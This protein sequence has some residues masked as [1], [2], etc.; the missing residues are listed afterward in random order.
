MIGSEIKLMIQ[1]IRYEL[2]ENIMPFWMRR[3]LDSAGNGFIGR[4]SNDLVVD[5]EAPKGLILNT[6]LL[7]SF[8]AFHR[9]TKH[10]ESLKMAHF[11][12]D[13]IRQYFWDAEHGGSFW[14]LRPDGSP[15]V[16]SKKIYG[17]A[18]L[19]YAM[20]EYYLCTGNTEALNIAQTTFNLIDQYAL[21]RDYSGYFEV[22]N[23]DWSLAD[24]Q[25]LGDEDM[26]EKKSMNN[27]LHLM[28][29]F[30]TLY[31]AWNHPMIA[32][33]LQMVITLFCDTILNADSGHLVLFF[34][35]GWNR[36]SQT[37][38]FGHDIEASWLLCEA[39]EALGDPAVKEKAESAAMKIAQVTCDSAINPRGGLFYEI[40]E[41][42][43]LNAN[44]EY[45]CQAEAA[46][47][48]LNAYQVTRNTPFLDAAVGIWTYIRNHQT[49]KEYG[50]W[51][52]RIGADNT[53]VFGQPKVS[54]WKDP[55]H[56]GR[57]CMEL[58]RRLTA[59]ITSSSPSVQ[60]EI[61]TDEK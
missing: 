35:Q 38:S 55:Y 2:H 9:F 13:Y 30:S 49:D 15:L 11:T 43:R 41:D 12:Y 1:Q 8:S 44:R 17:Q 53:P 54:E 33:R 10:P 21:D 24:D 60:K 40:D 32:Q 50:E 22:C 39:A 31:R 16:T 3:C 61:I 59:L 52:E 7:W 47:G 46:V 20:A 6:R 5:T 14:M 58:I 45:W 28:E 27:H 26:N 37:V 29:A 42:G 48:F 4:M 56:N 36:K 51:F 23:R 18:F 34:D 19:I 25:R 57:C